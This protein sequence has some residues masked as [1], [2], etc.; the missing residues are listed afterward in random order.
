MTRLASVVASVK[1]RRVP[2]LL[3]GLEIG[4]CNLRRYVLCPGTQRPN[5][6]RLVAVEATCD[7]SCPPSG[8]SEAVVDAEELGGF[9]L[10]SQIPQ[11]W[12]QTWEDQRV[13]VTTF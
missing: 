9:R 7:G 10:S 13:H 6:P 2:R 11:E 12:H 1:L 3:I 8:G 4:C 5:Q